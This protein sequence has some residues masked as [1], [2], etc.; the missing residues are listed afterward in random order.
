MQLI[1]K[2]DDFFKKHFARQK[3]SGLYLPLYEHK[4]PPGFFSLI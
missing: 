3:E 4:I 2:N 1:K